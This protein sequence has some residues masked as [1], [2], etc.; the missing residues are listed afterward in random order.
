MSSSSEINA[1]FNHDVNRMSQ[2]VWNRKGGNVAF[3]EGL[4]GFQV[5]DLLPYQDEL[6]ERLEAMRIAD[7]ASSPHSGN[8]NI[9]EDGSMPDNTGGLPPGHTDG[10][11]QH[12]SD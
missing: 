6:L 8:T 10:S 7:L 12:N 4:S 9:Q 1:V 5:E 2:I 11:P 3:Y